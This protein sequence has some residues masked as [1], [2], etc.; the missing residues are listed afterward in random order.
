MTETV[1]VNDLTVEELMA[2]A[3]IGYSLEVHQ[4]RISEVYYG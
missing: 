1:K 2:L 3:S 4:G